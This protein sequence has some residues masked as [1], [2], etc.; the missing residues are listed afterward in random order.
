MWNANKTIVGGA[1]AMM[2][3]STS[4]FATPVYGTDAS[5]YL[6]GSRSLAD[7][8]LLEAGGSP[9]FT[10]ASLSWTITDNLN[11]SYHYAYSIL[12]NSPNG[13]SHFIWDVSDN[14]TSIG[15][16]FQNLIVSAGGTLGTI[17]F[18]TYSGTSQGNSNPGM[19]G[20]FF[21]VKANVTAGLD[22]FS[23][24]FDSDRLPVW[25]DFYSKGGNPLS[26]ARN[27]NGFAI[28]NAGLSFEATDDNILH[29]VAMPDTRT[30]CTPGVNCP[31]PGTVPVPEPGT[32][33]LLGAGL[34][35]LGTMRRRGKSKA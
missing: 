15:N 28:F 26:T 9:S 23:F 30:V 17:V 20:S 32:L 3:A 24:A 4:A 27:P 14:C 16:C 22:D 2:L 5:G 12:T 34:L 31:D 1:L 10:A 7:G 18:D 8:G 33:A 29:F 13:V 21:G 25:A 11:G 19:P 35:G 6:T